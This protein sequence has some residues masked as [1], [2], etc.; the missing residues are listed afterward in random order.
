MVATA[1]HRE[2]LRALPRADRAAYQ[3][4]HSGLPGPRADLGLLQAAAD[5]GD[6]EW[7]EELADSPDKFRVAAG[8]VGLRRLLA[9]G[10]DDRALR[11]L[12]ALASDP[13]WRVR[14]GVAMGLQRLGDADLPCCGRWPGGGPPTRIR[15]CSVRPRPTSANRGCCGPASPPPSPSTSAGR[16]PRRW[17]G[18][19]RGSAAPPGVR[20]LRQAL[21]YCWSV[22]VAADP[23]TGLPRFDALTDDS[24]PDVAWIVQENGK[25][26]RLARVR[27]AQ[28]APGRPAGPPASSA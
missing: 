8:A 9:D 22:A 24:D 6:A 13:R 18:A 14:E 28:P 21:G 3:D 25:K 10:P 12:H 16:S 7:F 23:G 20:S 4:R 19:P 11:L 27:A 26:A 15:S 5:T 17:P 2:A 1:A